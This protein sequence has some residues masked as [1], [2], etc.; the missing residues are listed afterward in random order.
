M[1]VALGA[2]LFMYIIVGGAITVLTA[3]KYAPEI[4]KSILPLSISIALLHQIG[5]FK[6]LLETNPL[7]VCKRVFNLYFFM[8]ALICII[9]LG[10]TADCLI[11]EVIAKNVFIPSDLLASFIFDDAFFDLTKELTLKNASLEYGLPINGAYPNL[12]TIIGVFNSFL[13]VFIPFRFIGFWVYL[14]QFIAWFVHKLLR[15]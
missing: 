12:N 6:T 15:S 9:T 7:T 2:T 8:H 3:Y 4:T 1:V 10:I 11:N 13:N 5:F 14:I